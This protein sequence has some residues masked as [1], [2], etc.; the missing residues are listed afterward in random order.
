MHEASLAQ[1]LLNLVISSLEDYNKKNAAKPAIQVKEIIC[2]AGLLAGFEDNTLR[3]CFEMFAE[4]T[5]CEKANLKINFIPLDCV[6]QRCGK[7]FQLERKHFICPF[8]G[9]EQIDFNGG[10]GL[11][12]QAINVDNEEES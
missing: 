10:S 8:C 5:A 2:G 9:C 11:I 12:L 7:S 3:A 4:G 1:G 6:C